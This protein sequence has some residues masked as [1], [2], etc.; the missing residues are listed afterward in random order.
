[1]VFEAEKRRI[2]AVLCLKIDGQD[3]LANNRRMHGKWSC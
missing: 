1:M 2:G 3:G